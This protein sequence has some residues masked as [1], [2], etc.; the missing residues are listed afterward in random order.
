VPSIYLAAKPSHIGGVDVDGLTCP[1]HRTMTCSHQTRGHS[2]LPGA[3]LS[4]HVVVGG[5]AFLGCAKPPSL[6]IQ[7]RVDCLGTCVTES[8]LE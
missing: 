7:W 6:D 1:L 4:H 8:Y 3:N 2:F 5:G